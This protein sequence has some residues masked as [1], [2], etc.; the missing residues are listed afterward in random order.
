MRATFRPAGAATAAQVPASRRTPSAAAELAMP[1]CAKPWR[2][3]GAGPASGHDHFSIGRRNP[4]GRVNARH[5]SWAPCWPP[6]PPASCL[7]PPVWPPASWR[8]APGARLLAP[9]AWLL[10][11]GP[12]AASSPHLL[13]RASGLVTSP[14][15]SSRPPSPPSPSPSAPSPPSPSP[16]SPSAPSPPS[17][18]RCVNGR[19][20]APRR[21][22]PRPARPPVSTCCTRQLLALCC[23]CQALGPRV[24]PSAAC[25]PPRCPAF[26][27]CLPVGPASRPWAQRGP[28]WPSMAQHGSMTWPDLGESVGRGH[29]PAAPS[30]TARRTARLYTTRIASRAVYAAGS[31]PMTIRVTHG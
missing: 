24:C 7:L 14:P 1:R 23:R 10:P 4:R 19:R 9:G 3:L 22:L 5:A 15:A 11:P 30:G 13:V 18:P 25:P 17:R 16:P 12:R 27:A 20:S 31:G 29:W 6:G 21:A 8:P 2:S 26:Q 28:A